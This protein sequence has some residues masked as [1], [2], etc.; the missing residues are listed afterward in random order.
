MKE[1]RLRALTH[2]IDIRKI[3]YYD[4]RNERSPVKGIDTF[5][6]Q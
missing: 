1:A 6:V 5:A 3:I 4:R 2:F